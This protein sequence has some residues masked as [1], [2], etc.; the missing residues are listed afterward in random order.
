[1]TV[2]TVRSKIEYT[3]GKEML[4]TY[5]RASTELNM[6]LLTYIIYLSNLAIPRGPRQLAGLQLFNFYNILRTSIDVL[7]ERIK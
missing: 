4:S 2:R 3:F 6:F 1:V 5:T 7:V